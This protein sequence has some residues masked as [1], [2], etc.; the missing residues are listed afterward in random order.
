MCVISLAYMIKNKSEHIRANPGLTS[1]QSDDRRVGSLQK[2]ANKTGEA[3][4]SSARQLALVRPM[5]APNGGWE[6]SETLP[7][8][9]PPEPVVAMELSL[10]IFRLHTSDFGL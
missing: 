2:S 8:C 7:N 1:N 10:P 6:R 3:E 4:R 5:E 9:W